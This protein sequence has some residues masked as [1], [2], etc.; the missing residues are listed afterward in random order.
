LIHPGGA[1]RGGTGVL[2]WIGAAFGAVLAAALLTESLPLPSALQFSPLVLLIALIGVVALPFLVSKW[3]ATFWVLLAWFM[4]ED[5]IRKYVGNDIRIYFMKDGLYLV[6]VVGLLLD[7]AVRG[8]WKRA[9]GSAAVWLY[10][11]IAWSVVLSIPM[12]FVDWRIPLIALKLDWQYV[13]LVITG[14]LLASE[15]DGVR[16][17][18]TGFVGLAIPV[19]LVGIIQ[20]Q[21]G[22]EFLRPAVVTEASQLLRL[23]LTRTHDV[24][25]PTGTFV[26]AGRFGAMAMLTYV[27][28]LALLLLAHRT[29]TAPWR[30]FAVLGVLVAAGAVWAYAGKTTVI[31]AASIAVIA[32]LAPV[33]SD[34]RLAVL[35]ATVAV[36]L[37]P[38]AVLLMFVLFPQLS[39]NRVAYLSERLDPRVSTNE[40]QSRINT[41]RAATTEGVTIGGA[42]GAGTGAGSLG[43]QYLGEGS[44]QGLITGVAQVE[45]GYASVGQQWGLIGLLLWLGWTIAWTG[46]LWRCSKGARG[47]PLAGLGLLITSWV[48]IFLFVSFVGGFQS[49]QNYYTNAYLWVFFGIVFAFPAIIG[50]RSEGEPRQSAGATLRRST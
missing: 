46:R 10:A 40:W 38:G 32:A 15:E 37:V 33:F 12:A 7:P 21:F 29:S 16:R 42:I 48:V 49:F 36:A 45:G 11:M 35:R 34:R 18:L 39:A 31:V 26:D 14:Y 3:R 25:Q 17:V 23:D 13:P 20:A 50:S 2:L 28:A 43:L 47:T 6:L 9:T 41:W 8:V 22:P 1:A 5:L 44:S 27:S 24:F 30:A 4:V 19:C